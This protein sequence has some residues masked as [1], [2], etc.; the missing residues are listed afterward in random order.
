MDTQLQ[1]FWIESI[2]KEAS[3]RLAWQLKYSKAFA[4]QAALK[5][6]AEATPTKKG[7][8]TDPQANIKR[9]IQ[10]MEKDMAKEEPKEDDAASTG[11]KE[12][13]KDD[14]DDYSTEDLLNIRE[15][16]EPSP[17]TRLQLYDGIS[18][19]GEGR[20]AYL[21][22]RHKKSPE[23]KFTFPVLSSCVYGWKIRDHGMPKS[24]FART[25]VIRDTFYRHSG[26]ITG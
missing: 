4:K 5:K 23:E 25:R 14:D 21:K 8:I 20:Y 15:M 13:K 18:H 10:L 17:K 9:R 6:K 12:L 3:L 24:E 2:K 11:S 26:I 1:N 7:M 19:H 22:L 16:R